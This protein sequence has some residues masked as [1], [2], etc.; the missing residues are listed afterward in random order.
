M[1]QTLFPAN[2]S[3]FVLS[4]R[5][6]SLLSSQI[7]SFYLY[8]LIPPS[9]HQ[10]VLPNYAF[11]ICCKYFSSP[12]LSQ[13]S[14]L[15]LKYLLHVTSHY[16]S[17]CTQLAS[18]LICRFLEY[19]GSLKAS[20]II[21]RELSIVSFENKYFVKCHESSSWIWSIKTLIKELASNKAKVTTCQ[22]YCVCKNQRQALFRRK[23][24]TS[25]FELI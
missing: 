24:T 17:L 18:F 6:T 10:G 22:V 16:R 12:V 20:L 8:D 5:K 4:S 3:L 23:R 14:L 7:Q 1:V 15:I 13:N 21:T 19:K 11:Y 9:F 25:K 2:F